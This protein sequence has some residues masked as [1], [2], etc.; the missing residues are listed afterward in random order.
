MNAIQLPA[1]FVV[2]GMVRTTGGVAG[3]NEGSLG[4]RI[5]RWEWGTKGEDA[6]YFP[7]EL[8][9]VLDLPLM[10]AQAALSLGITEEEVE[11]L[12]QTHRLARYGGTILPSSIERYRASE[13]SRK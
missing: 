12:C 6:T 4:W 7:D 11:R 8:V 9:T 2:P 10:P 3:S 5:I 1:K 13:G